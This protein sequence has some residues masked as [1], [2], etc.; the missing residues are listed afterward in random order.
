MPARFDLLKRYGG[1]DRLREA[2]ARSPDVRGQIDEELAALKGIHP[3]RCVVTREYAGALRRA[4]V[5]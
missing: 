3:E 4:L 2:V 5:V 1:V